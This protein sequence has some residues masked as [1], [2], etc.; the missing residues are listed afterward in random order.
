MKTLK[1]K[2]ALSLMLACVLSL[3]LAFA[4]LRFDSPTVSAEQVT[5]TKA[6]YVNKV[7]G[8]WYGEFWGNFTGLPTEFNYIASPNPATSVDWVTGSAFSTDDDTSNEYVFLHMM[9]VYGAN[10]ITYADMPEEWLYHLQ[11]HIWVGNLEAYSLMTGG[12][13]P[14]YTGMRGY[15]KS[16]EA[17]DAQ[18]ECEI[19]GLVTPAMLENC[20][21]RTKWWMAA[22]GDGAVLDNSAFYAMLCSNA[23]VCDDIYVSMEQVRSYFDDTSEAAKVYD[24]V[25]ES[26]NKYPRDWRSARRELYLKYYNGD[27]L[28]CKV[29][30]AMTL[31][32][33]FYGHNDY[34]GT[35]EIAVLAGF[36]NDCNAATAGVIIGT[37][38]G[39]DDLP[40]DLKNASGD[41]YLNTNRPGL[42][43]N[44]ID[45]LVERVQLQA[46]V[47]ITAAGGSVTDDGYVVKDG[48]FTPKTEMN[49]YSKKIPV[50][51]DCWSFSGMQKFYNPGFGGKVGYCTTKKGDYATVTFDGD[52]VALVAATSVGGGSFNIT[53]DGKDYGNYTLEAEEVFVNGKYFTVA[54]GQKIRKLRNLG[55]GSHVMKITALEDGKWHSIDCIEVVA[56]EEEYFADPDVNLARIGISTPICSVPVPLGEGS[57]SGSIAVICDGVYY[58]NGD[59]SSRQ[60]DSFLGR[61]NGA[62]IAKDYEDYVGYTFEKS[63]NIGKLVFNEGGHWGSDGGWFANGNIRVEV[64]RN[65]V[66]QTAESSVSPA[67]PTSNNLSAFGAAGETYVFTLNETEVDGVRLIGDGGGNAKIISCG[68][69]EIYGLEA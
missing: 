66:W 15:N 64:L 13:L 47:I 5:V 53:V 43:S 17:I 52:A 34:K 39:Y 60:Y 27:T 46:E 7:K 65:G 6:D 41:V 49:R 1:S 50:T 19:F 40:A 44:K 62:F 63:I 33:L 35:V 22:V 42:A 4:T 30:F 26:Y 29:N 2:A 28:D 54:Y 56:T 25:K 45:K 14:P 69:L 8:G 57:G 68:E 16:Y 32:S 37:Q 51:A 23:F 21:Q 31:M 11:S 3:A 20:Y 38:I 55:E 9:E 18:I 59:H 67:Y 10:D 58:H 36:D 24:A 61:N 48:A 12:I